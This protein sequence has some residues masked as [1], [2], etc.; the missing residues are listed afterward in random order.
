MILHH[1]NQKFSGGGPPDH[2]LWHHLH[3][4]EAK[5]ITSNVFYME[6]EKKKRGMSYS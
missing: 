6:R 3:I 1:F 5:T 4:Y 2:P